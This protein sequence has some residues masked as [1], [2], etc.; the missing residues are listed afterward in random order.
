MSIHY[1]MAPIPSIVIFSAN[2]TLAETTTGTNNK[3]I[4]ANNTF[5]IKTTLF[6][7]KNS[8]Y[9]PFSKCF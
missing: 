4:N 3:A 9:N 2:V 1:R 6:Y 5:F 7:L 8:T